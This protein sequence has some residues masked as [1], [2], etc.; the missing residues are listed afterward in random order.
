MTDAPVQLAHDDDVFSTLSWTSLL[1]GAERRRS[2]EE[3]RRR[4]GASGD[5]PGDDNAIANILV[6]S[7]S[8]PCSVCRGTSP[9]AADHPWQR[10]S[11]A[12]YTHRLPATL[13]GSGITWRIRKSP[14]T[15]SCS[16]MRG[17]RGADS[18]RAQLSRLLCI[19]KNITHS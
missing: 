15:R 10:R 16:P 8:L 13:R 1:G 9:G 17:Q 12:V 7:V 19:C 18:T 5:R 6:K 3:D 11:L 2:V 4:S 14:S